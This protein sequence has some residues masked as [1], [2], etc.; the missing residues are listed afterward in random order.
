[1]MLYMIICFRTF[2]K[3]LPFSEAV[4]AAQQGEGLVIIPIML[5]LGAL[6]L[7]HYF[8]LTINYGIIIYIVIA[9]IVNIFAWKNAFN[10]K[11]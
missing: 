6:A 4:V 9:F 1:M 2:S 11:V 5:I 8:V 10:I 3:A 7:V